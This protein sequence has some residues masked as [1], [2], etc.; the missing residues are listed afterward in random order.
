MFTST[1]I[2]KATG[3]ELIGADVRVNGVSTDTRTID[4]GALFVAVKGERFDGADYIE[5]AMK[6]GAAAVL[7]ER[8][9]E[10]AD[11][12]TILVENARTAQLKLARHYRDKFTAKLC[13]VTGSVGKTS[14]KDM[15]YA[16]NRGKFQ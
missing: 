12:P 5:Q 16:Q 7:S 15:I 9:C 6:N 2:A 11:I 8:V 4:K 13:G 3:G 14:T 1:E 10:N